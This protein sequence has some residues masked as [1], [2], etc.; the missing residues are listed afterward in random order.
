MKMKK[1][2]KSNSG[3]KILQKLCSGN[4]GRISK[5]LITHQGEEVKKLSDNLAE[6]CNPSWPVDQ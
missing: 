5:S 2:N 6:S 1:L 3:K 4:Q